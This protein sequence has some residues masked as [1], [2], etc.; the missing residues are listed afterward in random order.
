MRRDASPKFGGQ[1]PDNL[2]S[3]ENITKAVVS[4]AHFPERLLNS[5]LNQRARAAGA[6]PAVVSAP[7]RSSITPLASAT[8]ATTALATST[9]FVRLTA[10]LFEGLL[11]RAE[12]PV[13]TDEN[14]RHSRPP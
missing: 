13:P 3:P 9:A 11:P 12:A 1:A 2:R 7:F 10:P 5:L 8:M 4:T 6:S 14:F